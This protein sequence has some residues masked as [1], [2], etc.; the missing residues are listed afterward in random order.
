MSI[1]VNNLRFLSHLQAKFDCQNFSDLG[2]R[3]Y[4]LGSKIKHC[5]SPSIGGNIS[6]MNL[7]APLHFQHHCKDLR[8]TLV[9]LLCSETLKTS[10][11]TND[12]VLTSPHLSENSVIISPSRKDIVF[13]LLQKL[14][15]HH[16]CV[17]LPS[18]L[19]YKMQ[20]K[21]FF[22]IYGFLLLAKN[23]LAVTELLHQTSLLYS[24]DPHA[25]MCQYFTIVLL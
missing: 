4:S 7:F 21:L 10:L 17:H 23:H 8:A 5:L 16:S 6:Y 19:C 15:Q 13:P 14:K 25:Y 12:H 20:L 18:Y 24:I 9:F 1:T 2:K 3:H 11:K 22:Q